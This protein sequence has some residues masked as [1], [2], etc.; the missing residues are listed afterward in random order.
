MERKRLGLKLDADSK[1]EMI[2][3]MMSHLKPEQMTDTM[4]GLLQQVKGTE[5]VAE[6]SDSVEEAD[7]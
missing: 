3:T 4:R 5:T 6:D 7:T 1:R 2:E